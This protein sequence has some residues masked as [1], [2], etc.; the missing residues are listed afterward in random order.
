MNDAPNP[1]HLM[2]ER[3]VPILRQ[4]QESEEANSA[5]FTACWAVRG[6]ELE[7]KDR[8]AGHPR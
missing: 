7:G 8:N 6:W 2:P 3:V 5:H 4:N 1:T